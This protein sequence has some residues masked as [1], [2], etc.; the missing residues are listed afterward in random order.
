MFT[1]DEIRG[2][3][4]TSVVRGTYRIDDVDAFKEDIADQF[5][6][7][8]AQNEDLKTKM[9]TLATRIES[10]RADEE[11]IKATLLTA[12]RTADTLLRESNEKADF[13][14]KEADDALAVAQ[15]EASIKADAIVAEAKISAE[16]IIAQAQARSDNMLYDAKREAEKQLASIQQEI[17][18]ETVTL[19][20]LKKEAISFEDDILEKYRLHVEF[21]QNV[22]AAVR[23]TSS[24]VKE[25]EAESLEISVSDDS[26]TALVDD[27]ELPESA[28]DVKENDYIENHSEEEM[29]E[30]TF[31][32]ENQEDIFSAGEILE[33]EQDEEGKV[34][35]EAEVSSEEEFT[36]DSY[37]QSQS[38]FSSVFATEV[39]DSLDEDS[40]LEVADEENFSVE[41]SIEEISDNKPSGNSESASE[42][43]LD[44]GFE[45]FL[46]NLDSEL[47]DSFWDDDS[48]SELSDNSD[49]FK[50]IEYDENDDDEDDDGQNSNFKGFFK[51]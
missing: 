49:L 8:L 7:L 40:D 10:Y 3:R 13:M 6:A 32:I 16:E 9:T 34:A 19:D 48:D 44:D 4:F 45:V 20:I 26:L 39:E 29:E 11:N 5:E 21:I 50:T 46:D 35:D 30:L 17:Q 23:E 22:G 47:S 14:L 24:A 41:E 38:S 42:N 27:Y 18:N 1:S 51:K 31:S 28:L 43:G 15:A 36:L 2:F 12:Q 37:F 25:S 33:S